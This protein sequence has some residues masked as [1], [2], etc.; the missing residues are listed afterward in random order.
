MFEAYATSLPVPSRFE[1]CLCGCC[2]CDCDCRCRQSS[3]SVE[4][5][6]LGQFVPPDT[7]ASLTFRN[8][9]TTSGWS[10][11]L[12][13]AV[14][15]DPDDRCEKTQIFTYLFHAHGEGQHKSGLPVQ[16]G[17]FGHKISLGPANLLLRLAVRG[18]PSGI[19]RETEE[20]IFPRAFVDAFRARWYCS[21]SGDCLKR[22]PLS[23]VLFRT[24]QG[25]VRHSLSLVHGL[26]GLL[27]IEA[28]ASR[29][30]K[31]NVPWGCVLQAMP[32]TVSWP[33]PM[34]K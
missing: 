33:W 23:V 27:A 20:K 18:R 16:V 29:T 22:R 3:C 21:C 4:A 1:L 32:F 2:C 11:R 24:N 9:V 30:C 6:N 19:G 5:M 28:V 26:P 15:C 34:T 25:V 13:V 7:T 14:V 31:K 17:P 10:S 8:S 12:R